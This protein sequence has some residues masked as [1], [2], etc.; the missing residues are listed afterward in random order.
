MGR[1]WRRGIP[2][3]GS[4]LR[5]DLLAL[6][7]LISRIYSLWWN[8]LLLLLLILLNILLSVR[9]VGLSL[10]LVGCASRLGCWSIRIRWNLLRNLLRTLSLL[11][12]SL[13]SLRRL[14]LLLRGLLSSWSHILLRLLAQIRIPRIDEIRI[15]RVWVESWGLE[16]LLLLKLLL[17]LTQV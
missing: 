3:R 12:L 13:G 1:N 5:G 2:L 8:L 7:A 15:N 11:S 16:W 4:L 17:L 14:L 6:L 9:V 10:A